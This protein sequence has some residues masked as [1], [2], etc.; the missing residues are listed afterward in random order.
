MIA[1]VDG[2]I[3]PLAF[4]LEER[5]PDRFIPRYSMVMFHTIPYAQAQRRGAIQE[6]IL[7]ALTSRTSRLEEV[8]LA[9]ADTLIAERLGED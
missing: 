2:F 4:R 7:D 1:L 8:D 5:H 9:R 6:E 3:Q